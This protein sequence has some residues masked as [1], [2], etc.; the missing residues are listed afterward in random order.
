MKK[1]MSVAQA[2][3]EVLS[4]ENSQYIFC[5][6]GESYLGL[7]DALYDSDIKVI[8]TRHEGGASFMAEAYGKATGKP[9]LAMA[10]RG[11]GA[12]N[13]SIG[14]HTAFQDSTPMIIFIGQVNRKFKGREGFQEV[15]LEKYFAPISKWVVE[16]QHAEQI[17]EI[18][19]RAFF[20]ATSGRPGPVVIS[21]PEDVLVEERE[22]ELLGPSPKPPAPAP[23]N[24]ELDKMKRMIEN[25]ERP[26]IIAGG[27]INTAGAKKDLLLLAEK[28]NTPVISAFRRHDVFPH[29]HPLYAGQLGLGTPKE[30]IET[31]SEADVIIAIG[32]RLSEITT[33]DYSLFNKEQKIIQI[34]IDYQSMFKG[35]NPVLPIVADAKEAISQ[36][37]KASILLK[38]EK[39]KLFARKRRLAY[40]NTLLPQSIKP[41]ALKYKNIIHLLEKHLPK[42]A[43]ITNDAGNFAGWLHRFFK[44]SETNIYI[45]PTS[46]A[47]GYGLPAAIGA[48]LANQERTAVCL[49]GDGGFMMTAQELET[50]SR[51]NVPI[52]SIIFNNGMYGTIRMHQEKVYPNRVIATD[53]SEMSFAKLASALNIT[54]YIVHSE[55]DFE[56]ALLQ[57]LENDT[58][59]VIEIMMEKEQ[60]SVTT[61]LSDLKQKQH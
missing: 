59:A 61:T 25:A 9:G 57:A 16:V 15:D 30:I 51:Y 31:V 11:V 6:P 38:C 58:G 47:M 24:E 17:P 45:G 29:Q 22:F 1:K 26:I 13:L 19:K 28:W 44:F 7:L 39:A 14:I 21:L 20:V 42:D 48:K 27:G 46:G 8:A 10:T 3:V 23:G 40:E 34:D 36:L 35:S 32:T 5:V 12:A 43:I 33:Q 53:L 2:I 60:I 50:A 49:A 55:K 52:I 41:E 18:M 4:T 37:L 56:A 54:N